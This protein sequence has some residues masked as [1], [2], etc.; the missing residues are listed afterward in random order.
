ML[1]GKGQVMKKLS[2]VLLGLLLAVVVNAASGESQ[3]K[4]NKEDRWFELSRPYLEELRPMEDL[5]LDAYV[6]DKEIIQQ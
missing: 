6:S 5:D 4:L 2:C 3:V 1:Y